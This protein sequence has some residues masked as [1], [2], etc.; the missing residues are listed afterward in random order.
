MYL[1]YLDDAGS[2]GNTD[3]EYF[4]LG[5]VCV[6]EAQIDW[7]SREIDK[8]STPYSANPGDIEFH[9]STIF[10]RREPPWK[11]LSIDDARGV[12]KSVLRIAA[13]SY[14]TA[15][16]FACAIHKKSYPGQDPVELAFEDLCQRFDYFL[17]RLRIQ[18]DQQ[19][20]LLILDKT[21]RETSLQRLSREFRKAGTRWGALKY[22]AD[23]PLFVDSRASR[24]VQIADH[25]AY[26]VFR[27]YNTG[28]AQYFDIIASRFD[29]AD[30]VIH[31]LVHKHADYRTCTCPACLSRRLSAKPPDPMDR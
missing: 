23:T 24:L 26:S 25:V 2:P 28:D 14:G 12:L 13:A 8:L 7:F 15:R 6:Y 3:E 22:I 11:S 21:T 20:G 19:R 31:G 30:G 1:L 16:L 29:E 10:S 27:R 5:G 9:A 17:N 4:V 18:G